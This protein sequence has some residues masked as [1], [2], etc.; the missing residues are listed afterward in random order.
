MWL[1][2]AKTSGLLAPFLEHARER[3]GADAV[4]SREVADAEVHGARSL[5]RGAGELP[6]ARNDPRAASGLRRT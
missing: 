1:C 3:P 2:S 4:V 6:A 5:V